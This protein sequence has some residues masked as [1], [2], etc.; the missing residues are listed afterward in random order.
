MDLRGQEMST[1][2]VAVGAGSSA[3]AVGR[4]AS[5]AEKA[6]EKPAVR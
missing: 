1:I 3:E 5:G 4:R 6:N 2:R